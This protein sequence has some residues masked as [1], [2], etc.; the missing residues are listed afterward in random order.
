MFKKIID[1]KCSALRLTL[2]LLTSRSYQWLKH[3]QWLSAGPS[4]ETLALQGGGEEM[5]LPRTAA[6]T[7]NEDPLQR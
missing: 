2:Y 3:Y 7:T 5:P 1:T 6:V 4:K